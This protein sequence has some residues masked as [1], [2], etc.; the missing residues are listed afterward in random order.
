MSNQQL[1]NTHRA[2]GVPHDEAAAALGVSNDQAR[3][4]KSRFNKATKLANGGIVPNASIVSNTQ[5]G[6]TETIVPASVVRKILK[7]TPTKSRPKLPDIVTLRNFA[8]AGLLVSVIV[9]HSALVWYDCGQMWGIPGAIGGG[10]TFLIVLAAL[11][12]AS[13]ETKPRTSDTALWFVFFIDVAAWFVHFPT[14]K[15]YADIGNI[16][17]GMFAGFLCACSFAALYIFRDSKLD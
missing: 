13:D 6:E 2:N 9:G 1:Y 16:E 12:L 7:N 14:F 4:L 11:L 17:T 8:I 5:P 10:V 3:M 15:K